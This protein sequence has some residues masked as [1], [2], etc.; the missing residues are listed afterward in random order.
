MTDSASNRKRADVRPGEEEF[1]DEVDSCAG[2]HSSAASQAELV[3]VV[4]NA[5][6]AAWNEAVPPGQSPADPMPLWLML[7]KR[8][9]SAAGEG[10][11]DLERLKCF[12]LAGIEPAKSLPIT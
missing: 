12:A 5:M 4:T 6:A 7:A 1:V 11:R 3:D 10:E 9:M 8:I 2:S